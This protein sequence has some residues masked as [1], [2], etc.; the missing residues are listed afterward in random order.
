MIIHTYLESTSILKQRPD[1]RR[2]FGN[3]AVDAVAVFFL[4]FSRQIQNDGRAVNSKKS[5]TERAWRGVKWC[6]HVG[7]AWK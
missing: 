3:R 5:R 4:P 6:Q 7:G 1:S 2:E